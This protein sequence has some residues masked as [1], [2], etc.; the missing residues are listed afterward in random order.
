[1]AFMT[2]WHH[3]GR[4]CI[5]VIGGYPD[6]QYLLRVVEGKTT[7]RE[8]PARDADAAVRMAT[9]WAD[10]EACSL[11]GAVPADCRVAGSSHP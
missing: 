2:M 7:L 10:Q 9:R 4:R 3:N 8:E 1:M 6:H 11:L 5:L